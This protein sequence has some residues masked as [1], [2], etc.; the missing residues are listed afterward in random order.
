MESAGLSLL[1]AARDRPSADDLDRLLQAPMPG[2]MPARISHRPQGE[3]G[4]LE[5]LASGLTFDLS[6]LA[7]AAA[8]RPPSARH[9]FGLPEQVDS[10]AFEAITLRPGPHV[11][12]GM[13]MIP[14]VRVMIGLALRLTQLP[15]VKAVCW[16]PADCW[17]DAGYF[18]RIAGAWLA[19]GAFPA[20]GLAAVERRSDGGVE[21]DGLAFFTGQELCLE[22]LRNEP[23]A[24]T[25]K[26]AVR[27]IDYLIRQGRVDA[28]RELTGPDGETLVAEPSPDGRSVRVWRP[29]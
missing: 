24:E 9:F 16:H 23:A 22:P 21:S 3:A 12:A 2:A 15:A 10:F 29:A 7:P 5:L 4:W 8:N 20:L 17:M 25:V 18:S 14:L 26:L 11:A 19:G 27:V 13:A 6:G 1:F 28:R